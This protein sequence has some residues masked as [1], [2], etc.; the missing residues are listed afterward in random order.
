MKHMSKSK[1][2]FINIKNSKNLISLVPPYIDDRGF[3]QSIINEKH[4]NV[5]IIESKKLTIRSNHYHLTDSH[6]MY[7]LK[8]EYYY[9]FKNLKSNHLSRLKIKKNQLIF[10][11]PF[12]E[13]ATIFLK[14]TELLV[15][16][17]NPRDQSTYEK[18][19]VRVELI[20]SFEVEDYIG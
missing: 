5:S 17:K 2:K 11:P 12:E 14:N 10:T 19:T 6:Y 8:G 20:K 13:H 9:F 1:K 4:T 15:I 16:S 7:T 18:D 3:I